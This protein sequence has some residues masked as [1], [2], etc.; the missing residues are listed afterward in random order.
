MIY[1]V[2]S[3]TTYVYAEAATATIAVTGS[4]ATGG[5]SASALVPYALPIVGGVLLGAGINVYLTNA[6]E[7]AGMT[8]SQFIKSKIN[9]YCDAANT[10]IGNFAEKILTG[11]KIVR[12]GTI[13]LTDQASTQIS[14][15]VN[16]LKSN[17]DVFDN[18]G[19]GSGDSVT[20]NGTTFPVVSSISVYINGNLFETF[21]FTEPCAVFITANQSQGTYLGFIN[22][23]KVSYSITRSNGTTNTYNNM[24]YVGTSRKYY[25]RSDWMSFSDS[26]H[27]S[28]NVPLDLVIE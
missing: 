24:T 8:K 10:T 16:W 4:I 23:S 7:Q 2:A 17:N 18:T 1:L 13:Q 20:L 26:V 5:L 11:A 28:I 3:N 9:S 22:P 21:D 15:F 14:Q 6:S 25:W 19:T 12:D 27:A